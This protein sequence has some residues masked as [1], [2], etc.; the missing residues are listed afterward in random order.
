MTR[1]RIV[2][3]KRSATS[4]VSARESRCRYVARVRG[5]VPGAP[6]VSVDEAVRVLQ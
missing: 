4:S 3:G 6:I 5:E 2:S 1:S